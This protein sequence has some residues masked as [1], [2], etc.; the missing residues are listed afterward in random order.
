MVAN[1]ASAPPSWYHPLVFLGL[2]V[3]CG[4]LYCWTAD[5][6]MDFDDEYY[7]LE[8]P[9]FLESA[10]FK[11]YADLPG[12]VR[13][14]LLAGG[15]PDLTANIVLRPVAYL[16]FHANH[17]LD[18][19]TPRWYRV[20]NIGI[21]C[22]NAMLV[23]WLVALLLRGSARGV[24]LERGS[25]M[26]I[27]AAS[28]FLFAAH[29]MAP[30][31][32][33]YIVQR[34]TS[35]GTF[36]F[37]ATLV[38]HFH[39][40]NA[41]RALARVALRSGSVA[42][43]LLGMLTKECVFTAPLV[44]V[45]LDW[46]L[47]GSRWGVAVRRAFPLLLCMPLIPAQVL[48]ISI[49]QS[50]GDWSLG[51]VFHITNSRD[52]PVSHAD[53]AITQITVVL[54]YLRQIVWPAGLNIDPEWPLFRSLREPRVI[55][56]LMSLLAVAGAALWM[57][58][59]RQ[60]DARA[61]AVLSFLLWFLLTVSISSGLVPLPDFKAD[62]RAYLPSIGIIIAVACLLDHIRLRAAG[63]ARVAFVG[64]LCVAGVALGCITVQR[65]EIWRDGISLW[66]DAAAKSPGKW[67][68]WNNLGASYGRAGRLEESADAFRRAVELWPESL[69]IRQNLAT[70]LGWLG[71]W[72]EVL[73][74]LLFEGKWK[75]KTLPV[76]SRYHVALARHHLGQGRDALAA[77][78]DVVRR[79]P[80]HAQAHHLL[81]TMLLQSGHHVRALRH[82]REA[83]R[84]R[85]DDVAVQKSLADGEVA[86]A[87][88]SSS[89]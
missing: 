5:F 32:V 19:F 72:R 80:W 89:L 33:T 73:D 40:N 48:W 46:L 68:I 67:R 3:L 70:T 22:A 38:L 25:I 86:A 6:P 37:L 41:G 36:F 34:F 35:L 12:F 81:G 1:P 59:R 24:P 27:A 61:A 10:G 75:E 62:H 45:L 49:V 66:S 4:G 9:A 82:L 84:L 21:H 50:G 65:N 2:A 15:D 13:A 57:F 53:Y 78:E 30:E 54:D 31:S 52:F 7:L 63:P 60:D 29:P 43:V 47:S 74:V 16:T 17:A 71:R 76:N 55:T 85:P 44:A 77:L 56:A 11:H 18:G 39:A 14:P 64:A 83:A 26:F 8:N 51:K 28:A 69:T 88:T 23:C 87:Q 20:A 79:A 58:R 42:A